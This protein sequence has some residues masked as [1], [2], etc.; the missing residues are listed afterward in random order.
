MR[1]ILR[2][3][4]ANLGKIGDQ[5]NV[6]RGFARNFLIPRGVAVQ[7]TDANMQQFEKQRAELEAKEA[8]VLAEAQKRAQKL[9]DKSIRLEAQ[10]GDEGKLFGSIGPR[11]IAAAMDKAGVHV[12]KSE[13]RMPQGPIRQI[14]EYDIRVQ[15]HSEVSVTVKVNVVAAV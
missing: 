10:A 1:V 11:D 2:E 4:V 3:K 9:T 15:L 5:V 6:K 8:H 14:G 12:E 7:A 13:I